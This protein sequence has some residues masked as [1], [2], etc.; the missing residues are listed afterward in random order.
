LK[1]EILPKRSDGRE[2]STVSWEFDFRAEGR[3]TIFVKWSDFRATY[4]GKNKDDAEPLDLKNIKRF[5]IMI[6]RYVSYLR[7]FNV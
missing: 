1:D 7:Y 5:G 6:R 4:R 2:Q 3:R